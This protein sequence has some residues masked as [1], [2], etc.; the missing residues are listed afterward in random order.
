MDALELLALNESTIRRTSVQTVS[1]LPPGGYLI[2]F[3]D[4]IRQDVEMDAATR[5]R[6]K[7]LGYIK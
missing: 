1:D 5:D 7:A 3:P 4:R 2:A 6:L